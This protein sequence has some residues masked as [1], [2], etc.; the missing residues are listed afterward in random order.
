MSPRD[1]TVNREGV[2]VLFGRQS[3]KAEPAHSNTSESRP[4]LEPESPNIRKAEKE[5]DAFYLLGSTID[6]IEALRQALRREHGLSR[7]T[8]SKSA[9][10]DAAIHLV[11]GQSADLAA[12]LRNHT[13]VD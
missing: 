11:S 7:R 5:K 8:A 3:R 12:W 2:D 13:V 4:V 10:V 9:V 6:T 1:D